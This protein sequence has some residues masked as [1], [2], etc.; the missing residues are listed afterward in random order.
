MKFHQFLLKESAKDPDVHIAFKDLERYMKDCDIHTAFDVIKKHCSMKYYL[1]RGFETAKYDT[2]DFFIID[3][4]KGK[5]SSKNTTNYYTVILDNIFDTV[6]SY[7]YFPKRSESIICTT[8]KMTASHYGTPYV[9]LPFK[10]TILG[11]VTED[12]I[13]RKDVT[14]NGY[15][16]KINE[17]NDI[18]EAMDL[19]E[20]YRSFVNKLEI[21]VA[22]AVQDFKDTVETEYYEE[23]GNDKDYD[24]TEDDIKDYIDNI[25]DFDTGYSVEE[26]TDFLHDD[27]NNASIAAVKIFGLDSDKVESIILKAYSPAELGFEDVSTK[28]LPTLTNNDDLELWFSGKAVAIKLKLW[29]KIKHML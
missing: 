28:E 6:P 20:D 10:E 11:S 27:K 21:L 22:D 29:D 25:Y 12:D 5:R 9:I 1:Y 16:F 26:I 14:I 8:S 17:W 7:K 19:E 15:T 13:W 24:A 23:H 4:K 18:F 2:N 3:T